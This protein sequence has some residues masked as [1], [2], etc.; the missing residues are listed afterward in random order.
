MDAYVYLRVA[1]GKVED[2]V[3]ALR[4]RHGV[5]HAAAVVGEWDVMAA[6]EGADFQAIAG[7]VLRQVQSVDGVLQTTT[8]PVVPLDMLGIHGGGWALPTI[9]MHREGDACYV[10]VRAAAGSVAAI[11]EALAELEPV[12]GVAV[13]AGEYDVLAEIALPWERAAPVILEQIHAIPGVMATSTSV[14]LTEIPGDEVEGD[15]FSTWA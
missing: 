13:V 9:P 2:V 1:P 6:V 4:G 14:S 8:T 11:V 5:R 3:I 10:H 15:Q 7:T 12:T